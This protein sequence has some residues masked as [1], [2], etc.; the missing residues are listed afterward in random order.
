MTTEEPPVAAT[1]L[2]ARFGACVPRIPEFEDRPMAVPGEI[3]PGETAPGEIAKV[4]TP[5]GRFKK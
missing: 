3:A 4:P 1:V 2:Q 5:P